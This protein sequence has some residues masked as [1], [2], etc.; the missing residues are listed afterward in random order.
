MRGSNCHKLLAKA[1]LVE[2]Q[3]QRIKPNQGKQAYNGNECQGQQAAEHHQAREL[4][5]EP[6][7][8]LAKSPPL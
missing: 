2:Q 6:V 1:D 5:T 3:E 8:S 4:R 7:A